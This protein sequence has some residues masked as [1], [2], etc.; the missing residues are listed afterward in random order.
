M[1]RSNRNIQVSMSDY[2][3][4]QPN[5]QVRQSDHGQ[6]LIKTSSAPWTI[7]PNEAI[8]I[9]LSGEPTASQTLQIRCPDTNKVKE[10]V[11]TNIDISWYTFH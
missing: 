8:S 11:G 6:A 10:F 2:H 3:E 5:L 1:N 4:L 7:P 9:I